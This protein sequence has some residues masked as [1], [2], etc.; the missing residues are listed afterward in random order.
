MLKVADVYEHYDQEKEKKYLYDFDDLLVRAYRLLHEN[1]SI[2]EKYTE[3]YLHLLVDEYQDTNPLQLEILKTLI[4]GSG[5]GSSFWV[6]GDDWQSIYGFISASVR[7]I[8]NFEQMFPGSR[9]L[10]SES[11]LPKHPTDPESL[12]EPHRTQRTKD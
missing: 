12:P 5:N 2:R 1:P 8:I 4:E 10:H 7:N 11:Q 9:D 3:R 6:C